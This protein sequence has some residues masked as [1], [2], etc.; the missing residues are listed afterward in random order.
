MAVRK[1]KL[2]ANPSTQR[3]P[4]STILQRASRAS[5]SSDEQSSS[6]NLNETAVLHRAAESR[7]SD[8]ISQT[9]NSEDGSSFYSLNDTAVLRRAAI[10]LASRKAEQRA[11]AIADLAHEGNDSFDRISKALSDESPTVRSAAVRALYE[12]NPELAA[13]F[14]NRALSEGSSEDRKR[15]GLAIA[16]TEVATDLNK[17]A[18]VE[19]PRKTYGEIS[20]LFLLAKAGQVQ[21]LI[22]VIE[23]HPN[24]QLRL[25]VIKLLSLR[26]EAEVLP[27]FYQLAMRASLPPI[28]RSA[29]METLFELKSKKGKASPST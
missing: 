7:Q 23:E 9:A 22:Q 6:R 19:D 24:T 8:S 27:A 21:S 29:V 12:I 17:D 25:A 11:A 1:K 20:R 5:F 16:G 3:S 4:I 10:V 26:E 15:I 18:N 13:S 14:L 2:G 28:I